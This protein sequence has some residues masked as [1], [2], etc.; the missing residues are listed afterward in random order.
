M[1]DDADDDAVE[2]YPPDVNGVYSQCLETCRRPGV[3]PLPRDR[4]HEP[5]AE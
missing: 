3:E 4:A 5:I 1:V 2:F